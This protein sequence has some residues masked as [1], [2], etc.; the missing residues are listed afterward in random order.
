M[1]ET[2]QSQKGRAAGTHGNE[3]T[4]RNSDP[5]ST[6]PSVAPR[7]CDY[8]WLDTEVP[9]S[10]HPVVVTLMADAYDRHQTAAAPRS[11]LRIRIASSTL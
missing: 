1:P 9:V 7:T 5:V 3:R 10:R 6:I 4:L 11:W 2:N 8:G